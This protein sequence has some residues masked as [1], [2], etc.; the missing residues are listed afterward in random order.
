MRFVV[1]DEATLEWAS[2]RFK[3]FLAGDR[4]HGEATE[5]TEGEAS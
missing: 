1:G 4:G 5:I 2:G 3:R